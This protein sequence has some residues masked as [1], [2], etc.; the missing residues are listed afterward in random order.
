MAWHWAGLNIYNIK[1]LASIT[2]STYRLYTGPLVLTLHTVVHR[3]YS[4]YTVY[5]L[6]RRRRVPTNV[7]Y[8]YLIQRYSRLKLKSWRQGS[9][10][11]RCSHHR[12]LHCKTSDV[13]LVL[14]NL[15][16]ALTS[17]VYCTVITVYLNNSSNYIFKN[18]GRLLPPLP[19]IALTF[20][21]MLNPGHM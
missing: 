18:I 1:L 7:K 17:I 11:L 2:E 14:T 3:V 21:T 16:Q 9:R 13:S 4:V 20:D 12:I 10:Y 19:L 6:H 5:N 8:W 15:S